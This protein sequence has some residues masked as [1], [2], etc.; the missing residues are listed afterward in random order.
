MTITKVDFS[1]LKIL[2]V[3]DSQFVRKLVEEVLRSFGVGRVIS[4]E[5]ADQGFAQMERY[6]PD[7]IICDWQMY[8]MDGIAF[9]RRLRQDPAG[10]HRFV[11]F[12]MLTGHSGTDDVSAAIGEGADSYIVKPFSA[13]TLMNHLL[14]VIVADKNKADD[15]EAWA[16]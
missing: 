7:V 9:L 2:V 16:V 1:K 5:S 14:K 8:P 13:Q 12:I 6:S 3:D 15:R 11:P 10:H 4:A